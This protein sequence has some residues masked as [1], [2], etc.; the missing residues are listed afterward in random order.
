MGRETIPDGLDCGHL[1]WMNTRHALERPGGPALRCARVGEKEALAALL[2]WL[3]SVAQACRDSN[4]TL[5]P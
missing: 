3:E 4:G 2:A 1:M 5:G